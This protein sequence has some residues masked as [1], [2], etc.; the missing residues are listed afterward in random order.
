MVRK[1]PI[2]KELWVSVASAEML[3]VENGSTKRLGA[4]L[5]QGIFGNDQLSGR[6]LR[7]LMPK[8]VTM[9]PGQLVS[10]GHAKWGQKG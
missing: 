6:R 10:L 2:S 5:G 4:R 9:N 8:L 7:Q 3:P 1:K